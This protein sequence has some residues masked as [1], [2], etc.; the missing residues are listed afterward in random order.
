[1]IGTRP[2]LDLAARLSESAQAVASSLMNN[3]LKEIEYAAFNEAW[4]PA[5]D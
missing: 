3:E 2:T 1:M 5:G 4:I